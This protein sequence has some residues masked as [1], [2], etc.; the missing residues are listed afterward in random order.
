M[1]DFE[2][3]IRLRGTIIVGYL[4]A[5]N[6][7]KQKESAD[8]KKLPVVSAKSAWH[9]IILTK[10]CLFVFFLLIVALLLKNHLLQKKSLHQFLH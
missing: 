3:N 2:K 8:I 7:L 10:Y 1:V 4:G 5:N 6:R 9:K